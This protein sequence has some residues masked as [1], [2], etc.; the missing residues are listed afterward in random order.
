MKLR[1]LL[2]AVLFFGFS[3]A[4]ESLSAEEQDKRE[5]NIQAGNPFKKF[6][7]KPKIAT[8]SK[9]KYLEW[10]DLDTIVR[11][12]SFLYHVKQK[13]LW[14]YEPLKPEDK[15]TLRPEI[16]SRWISPDPLMEEFPEWSPYNFTLNNPIR[17]IDPDGRM[18]IPFD[19]GDCPPNCDTP[20]FW[21]QF[22]SSV[23]GFA[24]GVF[25]GQADAKNLADNGNIGAAQQIDA[26]IEQQV[27]DLQTYA[28][29]ISIIPGSGLAKG[30]SQLDNGDVGAGLLSLGLGI[31]DVGTGG[32]AASLKTG[33]KVAAKGVTN[34]VP[35]RLARVIPNGK[36]SGML[37]RL[38]TS[39]V[40]VTAADDIVGLNANQIAKRLTIP[41]SKTGFQVIEFNTPRFGISSPIN[42]SDPGF[43][44][45]GRTAGG[46]REFTLPNQIIPSNSTI[47]I[48]R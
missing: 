32:G 35:G 39:D 45:F 36:S 42:R 47:R 21:E 3:Y 19:S 14:A 34:P 20:N 31:L 28:D 12:G 5:K 9:G 33:A 7:Y 23:S 29:A 46:A 38:G 48:I 24:K 2:I 13:Q 40:F 25:G 43:V 17:F 27:I 22:K 37:G 30:I 41:N 16:S 15:G 4:Q 11:I 26:K 10:H 18:A 6:G 8:L 44:G 1:I